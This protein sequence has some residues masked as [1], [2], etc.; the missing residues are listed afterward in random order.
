MNLETLL[1]RQVHKSWVEYTTI[2]HQAFLE[3][4]KSKVNSTV[5]KPTPKD[6]LKLSVFNGEKF[7]PKA[8]Y[9][10]H[11]SS[12]LSSVGV[13]AVTKGECEALTPLSVTE[14]NDPFDGHAYIDFTNV[15]TKGEIKSMAKELR[16]KAMLRGWLYEIPPTSHEDDLPF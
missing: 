14:D 10:K 1:H 15:L 6:L 9:D 12:G 13:I 5:F 8:S 7:T 16:D 3:L 2:S 11:I 4:V